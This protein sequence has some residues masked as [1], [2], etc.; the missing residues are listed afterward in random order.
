MSNTT[1]IYN[2]CL[3][4]YDEIMGYSPTCLEDFLTDKFVDAKLPADGK[5]D[6]GLSRKILMECVSSLDGLFARMIT[7]LLMA[8]DLSMAGDGVVFAMSDVVNILPMA[9]AL[10]MAGTPPMAGT[11]DAYIDGFR[12]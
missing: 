10:W 8:G 2:R 5:E 7:V 3:S 1:S 4:V 9:R 6:G 11:F 12:F